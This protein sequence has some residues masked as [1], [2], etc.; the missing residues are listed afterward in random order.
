[1]MGKNMTGKNMMGM[2]WLSMLFLVLAGCV[3][4]DPI[5]GKVSGPPTFKVL[6]VRVAEQTD[7]GARLLIL[8]EA[9]NNNDDPIGL[10]DCE[11]TLTMGGGGAGGG[12]MQRG[13]AA[14]VHQTLPARSVQLIGLPAAMPWQAEAVG[15]AFV[16]S[17]SIVYD[18]PGNLRQFLTES[19]VPLPSASFRGEGDVVLGDTV[20]A[21]PQ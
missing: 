13:F 10:L 1:M 5:E 8:L 14:S 3:H 11:Y 19:S 17:G 6:G 18:P 4:V 21:Q 2:K 9:T 7:D 20:S 12:R 15:A 16:A